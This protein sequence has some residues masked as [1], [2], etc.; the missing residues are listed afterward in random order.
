MDAFHYAE[1]LAQDRRGLRIF[2]SL[3]KSCGLLS[4]DHRFGERGNVVSG[5]GHS[6]C[7]GMP[8]AAD[9]NDASPVLRI[10]ELDGR[11]AGTALVLLCGAI[12]ADR[13]QREIALPMDGIRGAKDVQGIAR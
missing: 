9:D 1:D 3:I 5:A 8:T 11:S 12:F 2:S 10:V 6:S 4:V 13:K 7:R